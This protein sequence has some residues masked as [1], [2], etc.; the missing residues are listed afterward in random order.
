MVSFHRLGCIQ[1][2]DR[3]IEMKQVPHE[4]IEEGS[5][6]KLSD[7]LIYLISTHTTH[8]F[9][10][11]NLRLSCKK[12]QKAI[13]LIPEWGI[14]HNR[15]P[16]F[17]FFKDDE[18]GL[19]KVMDPFRSDSHYSR[20]R[21]FPNPSTLYCSNNG[22][23]IMISSFQ[24][25]SSLKFFN[26][27]TRVIID[28]PSIFN[29]FFNLTSI[30]FSS[31][32]TS[33]DFLM[34]AF[35]PLDKEIVYFRFGD[36][37]WTHYTFPNENNRFQIGI[38]NPVY[39]QGCF[40]ILDKNGYLGSFALIDGEENWQ[41]YSKPPQL[42]F[43]KFHSYHLLE[44][45]G[46]LIA[47]F[48]KFIGLCVQVFKFNIQKHKWVEIRNLGE[49]SFFLGKSSFSAKIA[50]VEKRNRIYISR[51]KGEKIIFYSLLTK[52]FHATG[53]NDESIQDFY[54]TTDQLDSFW[55]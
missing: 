43:K 35:D 47:V 30:G 23:L 38:N 26:P 4:R 6:I 54:N 20:L 45:E 13:P 19:C 24:G 5:F 3:I 7:Y 52:Q 44:C 42:C 22:W 11:W 8:F 14:S 12:C 53:I 21:I 31:Y 50:E 10:Y 32:P 28:F 55:L 25:K 27:F 18:D 2:H 15:L 9:D 16:L 48:I 39:I 41:V 40:Y 51:L 17:I 34:V 46:Q 37:S 1:K 33:I 29:N 36:T 49:Y